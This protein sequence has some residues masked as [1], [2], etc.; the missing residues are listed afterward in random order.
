MPE[1][2]STGGILS[3]IMLAAAFGPVGP[4]GSASAGQASWSAFPVGTDAVR[5]TAQFAAPFLPDGSGRPGVALRRALTV[6][7][8]CDG[9]APEVI[10]ESRSVSSD[11]GPQPLV[12]AD[13]IALTG[14]MLRIGFIPP[15]RR[16]RPLR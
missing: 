11:P 16:T 6:F 4:G 13:D 3:L 5:V 15:E 14:K 10:E 12:W 9:S 1:M 7:V 8:T 2:R